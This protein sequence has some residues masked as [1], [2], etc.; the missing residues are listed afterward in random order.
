MYVK[1][2]IKAR[3]RN[4]CCRGKALS[5]TYSECVSVGLVIQHAKRMRC[6]ILSS[7]ACLAVPYF[8]TLSHKRHDFR[9]KLLKIKCVF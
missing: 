6:I 8:S 1:G 4:H 3:S 5:V 7:V 2:N 9:K